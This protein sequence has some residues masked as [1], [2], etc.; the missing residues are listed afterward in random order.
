MH[1]DKS[2]W[3]NQSQLNK[4]TTEW[5]KEMS[6][7]VQRILRPFTLCKTHREYRRLGKKYN[8]LQLKYGFSNN[9]TLF[10]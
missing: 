6:P 8:I 7:N 1:N 2:A 3:S 9:L 10:V 5:Q 4:V